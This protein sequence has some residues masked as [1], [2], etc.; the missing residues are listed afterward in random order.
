MTRRRKWNGE[1]AELSVRAILYARVSTEKQ[2]GNTSTQDQMQKLRVAA[3]T[4]GITDWIE[5]LDDG[6]SGSSLD[7]PMIQQALA[8]LAGG[9]RNLIMVT[10]LDRLARNTAD[11]LD[12]AARCEHEGWNMIALEGDLKLD[13]STAIGKL[14]L[15]FV[16]AIAQFGRDQTREKI[17]SAFR[18]KRTTDAESA[19]LIDDP[20]EK[21]IVRLYRDE[22][23]SMGKVAKHLNDNH[24]PTAK[25]GTW[26]AN[27]VQRVLDRH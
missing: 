21:T 12:L 7:R 5:L 1:K 4:A 3:N 27:T 16:A 13:T 19:G 10:H 22:K 17:I 26:R 18:H 2:Q 9:Q 23:L 24:V 11:V 15:T 8:L 20:T 25:G 14:T 6:E